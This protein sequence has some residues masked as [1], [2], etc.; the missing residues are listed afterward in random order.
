MRRARAFVVPALG[1]VLSLGLA[2][3][4]PLHPYHRP[5]PAASLE[6]RQDLLLRHAVRI[7]ANGVLEAQDQW[8]WDGVAP[9]ARQD[10]PQL[11]TATAWSG[12]G[13]AWRDLA[14]IA[15]VAGG[16]AA[17][18]AQTERAYN[19]VYVATLGV[20][21]LWES[22]L[23]SRRSEAFESDARAYDTALAKDLGLDEGWVDQFDAL[24]AHYDDESAPGG[25]FGIG[26]DSAYL[27]GSD[28]Q[29]YV[30]PP[31]GQ[32]ARIPSEWTQG[33]SAWWGWRLPQG[34]TPG[35]ETGWLGR[36]G[37]DIDW[38]DPSGNVVSQ[39]QFELQSY[40]GGVNLSRAWHLGDLGR[41]SF[42]L[43][44]QAFAGVAWLWG[45]VWD[46]DPQGD[47]TG[48]Y[49]LQSWAPDF[50]L[51]LR[52]NGSV[53]RQGSIFVECGWNEC[54][55]TG[56]RVTAST[57]VEAGRSGTDVNARGSAASWNFSGPVVKAGVEF[58]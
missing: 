49:A 45:Q 10:A 17:A 38:T 40:Y 25:R 47:Q 13:F 32:G 2:A 1:L 3:C 53:A 57:G 8:L 14:W 33:A 15:A 22:D 31:H 54:R 16:L 46:L 11:V 39:Q 24:P 4:A 28:E 21:V 50:G 9:Y 20:F 29:S 30:A 7:D 5:P 37:L 48:S 19:G 52:L 51:S 44:P 55:F 26:L 34:W 12:M 43:A 58:F 27:S 36:N 35:L 56:A 23:L 41:A 42:S 6:L 18:G